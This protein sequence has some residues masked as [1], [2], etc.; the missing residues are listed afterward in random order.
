MFFSMWRSFGVLSDYAARHSLRYDCVVRM[1]SDCYF[2]GPLGKL[3]DYDLSGLNVYEWLEPKPHLDYAVHDHFGFG[4]FD[5][6][7]IYNDVYPHVFEIC[8]AGAAV[9]P[10][11][12]LGFHLRTHNVV[13]NGHPWDIW[14]WKQIERPPT[15][16]RFIK[17]TRRSL[18]KRI[19]KIPELIGWR[20]P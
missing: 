16:Q 15:Y 12:I 5:V 11:H 9:N 17:R 1:R 3:A 18:R 13:V 8:E 4:D 19:V 20:T 10:E 6:M 14:L 7:K 2:K